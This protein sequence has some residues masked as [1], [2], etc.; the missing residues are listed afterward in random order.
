MR[1]MNVSKGWTMRG[2]RSDGFLRERTMSD[3]CWKKGY[4]RMRL[5][6]LIALIPALVLLVS[7]SLAGASSYQQIGG[8]IIDPV[9]LTTGGAHSYVGP[10]LAPSAQLP[11]AALS[12]AELGSADLAG[13]N[14]SGAVLA[15]A[16][17]ANATLASGIQTA[18][19]LSN[20]ILQNAVLS[21]SIANNANLS[22]ADLSAA[23]LSFASLVGADLTGANLSAAVLLSA[24]LDMADVSNAD[25]TG[26]N[27]SLSFNL[28]TTSWTGVAPT[29]DEVTDFTG[30]GFD[31]VAAGWTFVPE[32]SMAMLMNAGIVGLVA[33][34]RRRMR[35]SSKAA[36]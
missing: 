21:F 18:A 35:S 6:I 9:Q 25:M 4:L 19:D 14:L 20:A 16:N 31:P 29:Y 7:G 10:N 36:V 23:D 22:S 15:S 27:F 3:V 2:D 12:A 33:A 13:A 26:A 30:T 34:S 17:L 5:P 11:S 32:P 24:D 8:A 28:G 1:T